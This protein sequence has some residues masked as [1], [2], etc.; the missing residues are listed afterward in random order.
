MKMRRLADIF[1]VD[2]ASINSMWIISGD[3]PQDKERLADVLETILRDTKAYSASA[4]ADIYDGEMVLFM[5]GPGNIQDVRALTEA[6]G[7][8]LSER[9]IHA[10]LTRCHALNT[11]TRVREAFLSHQVGLPAAKQIFPGQWAYTLEQIDFARQCQ[12]QIGRGRARGGRSAALHRRAARWRRG[13]AGNAGM[14][15]F[16]RANACDVDGG[17][18]VSA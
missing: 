7:S 17:K 6:I 9:Q 14:L 12:E 15:S 8:A 16:G 3:A 1:H 2:V 5:I 18:N 4:I 10:S 11:T 13:P